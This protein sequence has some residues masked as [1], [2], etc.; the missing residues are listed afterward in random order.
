MPS[1]PIYS[2]SVPDEVIATLN[3]EPAYS[4]LNFN[5][6]TSIRS[7]DI[8][9]VVIFAPFIVVFPAVPSADIVT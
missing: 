6:D 4:L 1:P 5:V 9:P 2:V 7:A 8:F 3:D